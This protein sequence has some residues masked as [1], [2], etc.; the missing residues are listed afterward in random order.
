MTTIDVLGA[1]LR[2]WYVTAVVLACTAGGMLYV[3]SRPAV[4]S[5]EVDVRLLA[6]AGALNNPL[7]DTS[8]SLVATAGII[9]RLV[10]ESGRLPPTASPDVTLTDRG[11]FRGSAVQLP[12]SGG[13]FNYLFRN[14]VLT[15]QAAGS[16]PEEVIVSRNTAVERIRSA[17]DELQTRAS[18]PAASRIDTRVVTPTSA[19]SIGQGR[20]TR[21]ALVVLLL[22]TGLTLFLCSMLDRRLRRPHP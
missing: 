14:P 2:R 9:E 3:T 15:V 1:V 16:S 21:A 18:V 4:Y 8:E 5:A 10:N 12:N 22:G 13:Q 19:V 11:I 20:P 17:L 7:L 6:P